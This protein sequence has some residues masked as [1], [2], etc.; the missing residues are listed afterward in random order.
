MAT[1]TEENNRLVQKHLEAFNE[2]DLTAF[3]E[4]HAE[5]V[6][7]HG[8]SEDHEGRDG[9]EAWARNMDSVFSDAEVREEDLFGTDDRVAVRF[10]MV[11]THD[12]P[13]HGAEPTGRTVEFSGIAIFRCEDG[14]IAEWWLESD[15]LGALQQLGAV[16]PPGD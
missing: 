2:E 7:F 10:T 16:E 14:Q 1:T 11:G 5:D 13:F 9:I 12:G 8:A 6:V 15:Q 3:L 4:L